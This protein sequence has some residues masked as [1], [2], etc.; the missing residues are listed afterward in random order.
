MD[1]RPST[2]QATIVRLDTDFPA[3]QRGAHDV[4]R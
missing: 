2:L 3:P 1:L 4:K